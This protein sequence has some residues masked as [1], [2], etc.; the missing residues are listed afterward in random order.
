MSL[1]GYGVALP[2]SRGR[3]RKA[4]TDLDERRDRR[5]PIAAAGVVQDAAAGAV[6]TCEEIAMSILD[7]VKSAGERIVSNAKAAASFQSGRDSEPSEKKPSA[8]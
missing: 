8:P 5:E 2:H 4:L 6:T 1:A 7:F 3:S